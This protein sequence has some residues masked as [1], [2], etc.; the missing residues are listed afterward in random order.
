MELGAKV[1]TADEVGP[2]EGDRSGQVR[3]AETGPPSTNALC[4]PTLQ[5]GESS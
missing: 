5:R 2:C 3:E 4:G 1:W